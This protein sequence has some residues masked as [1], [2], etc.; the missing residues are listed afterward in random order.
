VLTYPTKNF[1]LNGNAP[2]I[3]A[4]IE[5]AV[6]DGMDVIN[7]SLGEPEIEPA[8]D[9]VVAAINAAGRR[10]R[11]AGDRRR[12]RLRGL[13]S[14]QRLLARQR[15]KAITAAAVSKQLAIASSRAAARRRSRSR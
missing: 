10:R 7:L 14:R 9:L 2:E 1:G 6:K 11:R 15:P 8:R 5:A 4:G 12:Q 3:A 13:R